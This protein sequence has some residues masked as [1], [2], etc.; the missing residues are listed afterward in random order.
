MCFIPSLTVQLFFLY[1]GFFPLFS[2]PV[3]LRPPFWVSLPRFQPPAVPTG[4]S[5]CLAGLSAHSLCF[6][7][8]TELRSSAAEIPHD[9]GSIALCVGILLFSREIT[10]PSWS[11]HLDLACEIWT[12]FSCGWLGIA[13][14]QIESAP[15][16][17][18]RQRDLT[19]ISEIL[20]PFWGIG[21]RDIARF[22]HPFLLH[23]LPAAWMEA[24][25]PA[26]ALS[27]QPQSPQLCHH[28]IAHCR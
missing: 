2:L 10:V 5:L 12:P 4:P 16:F 13:L 7:P 28:S 22:Q 18:W 20:L 27:L 9:L 19:C 11:G 6:L 26:A 24:H 8:G 15:P 17:F 3:L 21:C 14:Y 23:P 1:F 25:A